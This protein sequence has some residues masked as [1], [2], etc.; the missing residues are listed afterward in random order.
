MLCQKKGSL[1]EQQAQQN[2]EYKDISWETLLGEKTQ[3]NFLDIDFN[4]VQC[5]T[6]EIRLYNFLLLR[7][8]ASPFYSELAWVLTMSKWEGTSPIYSN[9]LRGIISQQG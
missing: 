8:I 2:I 5:K 4:Q 3:Q 9:Q 7:W 1:K 6:Q